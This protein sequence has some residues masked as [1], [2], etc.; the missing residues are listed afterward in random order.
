MK[1]LV[2]GLP[3]GSLQESTYALFKKAGFTIKGGSRSY[4][5]S[6]DDEEIEIR[7]LRSQEM[8]R[9]VEHGMLDAGITGL[10]WIEANGSDVVDLCSLV[11]SKRSKRPVRWVLAVP[12][13]SD[14]SSVKDLEGKKIATEG[15]GLVERWLEKNG[16]K[17]EVE[18]SWGATEVK[19]PDFVDA[20]V[21]ITETG[22][23]LRANNLKIIETLMESY[24]KFFCAKDA[25]ADEWK[26]SKLE[27]I[28]LLL[29]AALDA[30]GKVLLK[31][32]VEEK[33]LET[34]KQLLPALHAPTI[35][36]LTD[37]GWFA[38]ETVVD[39]PVVRDII[40]A[41]KQAGA[42]G[43]IEISLNKVVA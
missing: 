3:K 20:I 34:V 4:F 32:N 39:E 33:N 17:A 9:Y 28:A 18:F 19:V 23:S 37:S 43:I 24:T 10:D 15:V 22:S 36:Q 14:I 42:E 6:I 35:N 29:T 11:Y 25:W 2:I 16:V 26:R 27:K 1:K 5:P 31:L 21:D 41:L 12:N 30:D 7:I 13:D 8:S 40:P 38:V